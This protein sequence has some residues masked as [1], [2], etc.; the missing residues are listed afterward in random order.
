MLLVAGIGFA[1]DVRF[2]QIHVHGFNSNPAPFT[3]YPSPRC[4]VK[5]TW[6]TEHNGVELDTCLISAAKAI[7]N[8]T[9]KI[10]NTHEFVSSELLFSP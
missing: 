5:T 10:S 2:V 7:N 4:Q 1:F 8:L 9:Y 3:G 6:R